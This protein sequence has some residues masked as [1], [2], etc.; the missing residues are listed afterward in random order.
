[1]WGRAAIYLVAGATATVVLWYL[2]FLRYNRRQADRVLEGIQAALAGKGQVVA[3]RWLGASLLHVALRLGTSL[4]QHPALLVRLTPRENPLRWL[5]QRWRREPATI[6]FEADLDI[7]PSFNLQVRQHRWSGRP[8]KRIS[9]DQAGWEF[10]QVTPLILTSRR[11]WQ[12]EVTAMMNTL[13]SCR[14]REVLSLGF[15]P[16]SPHFSATIPLQCISPE[17]RARSNVFDTLREL[18][19]GASASRL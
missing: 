13:L 16:T 11:Y 4:F 19:A 18:A 6:T 9:A 17:G 8:S 1:M 2:L 14:D 5:G 7:P 3:F 15:R 12:R 10:E